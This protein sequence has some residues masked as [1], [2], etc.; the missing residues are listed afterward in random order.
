MKQLTLII[1]LDDEMALREPLP[2]GS[3]I[4]VERNIAFNSLID[5]HLSRPGWHG[6]TMEAHK[7]T[8]GIV[9]E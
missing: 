5:V 9:Q 8:L 4:T 1:Q 6:L 7:V 3:R 2:P